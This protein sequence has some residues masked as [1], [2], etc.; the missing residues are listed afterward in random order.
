[1]PK[2][3]M[4][5]RRRH[6][7]YQL[8]T[9]SAAAVWLMTPGTA[10]ADCTP[11]PTPANG[12]VTCTGSDADGLTINTNQT[13]VNVQ[14]GATVSS[15]TATTIGDFDLFKTANPSPYSYYYPYPFAN[16]IT[17]NTSGQISGGLTVLSGTAIINH[18]NSPSTNVTLNV[19][20]GGSVSG[21]TAI[22]LIADPAALNPLQARA[23]IGID[24]SGS[25]QSTTGPAITGN[26]AYYS[27]VGFLRNRPGG[28]IGA[29]Q[30]P[31][32]YFYN[33]GTID[34]GTASAMTFAQSG[35]TVP[36]FPSG[37][38]NNDGSILSA[39]SPATLDVQTGYSSELTLY[40]SG[41]IRNAGS[42]SAISYNTIYKRM[43]LTNAAGGSI[44]SANG[45][46]IVSNAD[47]SISNSG[48]ISGAGTAIDVAGGLHL[49]GSGTITGSVNAGASGSA[50]STIDLS[51]GQTINGNL[52][53]GGGDDV[54]LVNYAGSLSGVP[55]V[56]GTVNAGGGT[57]RLTY[58]FASDATLGSAQTLPAT[59]SVLGLDIASGATVTLD[60]G[61]APQGLITLS[62]PGSAT[63]IN[64]ASYTVAGPAFTQ[65]YAY[66]P[67]AIDNRGALTVNLANPADT[68]ITMG[69]ASFAN[70]GSI[71]VNG[72]NG[73]SQLGSYYGNYG[74]LSTNSGSITA[75]ATALDI[76]G[77]KLTNSGTL[78]STAGTALRLSGYTSGPSSNSGSISGAQVGVDISYYRLINT[79]TIASP[80]TAVVLRSFGSLTNEASG[81]ID[82]NIGAPTGSFTFGSTVTNGGRIN[83]NVNFGAGQGFAANTF[84]ALDGSVVTGNLV[85]GTIDV[86]V[87]S[88]TNS[89]PGAYAGV[90][91]TVSGGGN[92]KLIYRVDADATTSLATPTS[93][94]STIGFDLA[95]NATL[96]L[97]GSSTTT[98]SFSGTGSVKISGDLTGSGPSSLINLQQYS[99]RVGYSNAI[100]LTSSGAL[101][102]TV[103]EPSLF[104]NGLV[105]SLSRDSSFT[106]SGTITVNDVSTRPSY[107]APLNAIY[108]LDGNVTNT[109]SIALG[110]V[111]GLSIDQSYYGGPD[112][113]NVSNS[114]SIT[115]IAGAADAVGIEGSFTLT[116]TGTISTGGRAISILK[117]S[118]ATTITNSG[119]IS[120]AHAPA[121]ADPANGYYSYLEPVSKIINQAGGTI[122]GGAGQSAIRLG[123]GV[124]DNAGTINGNV[125]LGIN[126]SAYQASYARS[127][128]IARGG[129]L[130]G[131]LTFGAGDDTLIVVG[132]STGV[133]GTIDAGGG[134]NTYA[135]LFTSS[136]SIDVTG[137]SLPATFQ[138]YAIGASGADTTLTVTGPSAG[139]SSPISFFGNGTIDNKANVNAAAAG[140]PAN[141]V[142]LGALDSMVGTTGGLSFVND[143]VLADGVSGSLR[144]FTNNGTVTAGQY[145]IPVRLEAVA[146]SDFSFNNTGQ[147][148]AQ[149]GTGAGYYYPAPMVSLLYYGA[150]ALNSATIANSGSISDGGLYTSLI[151]NQ[152]DV[153]NSGTISVP[154]GNPYY[155]VNALGIN[156]Y[157][158]GS[159]IG[160]VPKGSFTK[161][162]NTAA[163]T[164]NG[165]AYVSTTAEAL[166]I[167]N[168]GTINGNLI[169]DQTSLYT[170]LPASPGFSGGYFPVDQLSAS[171]TNSGAINGSL[172]LSSSAATASIANSGTVAANQN[173][174]AVQALVETNDGTTLKLTNSGTISNAA[175]GGQA[176]VAGAR[177]GFSFPD[178]GAAATLEV[179]NTGSLSAN[180]GA[181]LYS[182]CLYD[183][184]TGA[185]GAKLYAAAGLAVGASASGTASIAITN[186]AGATISAT[187]ATVSGDGQ[188]VPSALTKVGSIG[189]V[190]RADTVTLT[191][192]GTIS[193]GADM[194]PGSGIPAVIA[195][196]N[197]NSA[198]PDG[199]A[200]GVELIA[201]SATLTNAASGVIN[202]SVGLVTAAQGSVSNYGTINGNVTLAASDD[203]FVQ[204]IGATL[205]GIGDGGAGTDRLTIDI[206]GGGVLNPQLSH[207]I[208]FEST[209]LT[210]SGSVATSAPLATDTL[211]LDD[212]ALTIAAGKT[213]QTS[214]TVTLTGG[215]GTISITN[216]GTIAGKVVLGAGDESFM[217]GI[218]ASTGAVDGGAGTNSLTIDVSGGGNFTQAIAPFTN[219][220]SL[221]ATGTGTISASAPIDAATL[222][223]NNANLTLASGSTL[224]TSGAIALT[225]GTGTNAFTNNGTVNGA[226]VGV[227]TDNAAG[228]TVNVLASATNNARF[229][230]AA[231]DAT[232]AIKAGTY[233]LGQKLINSGL[234]A[235]SGG[236][237]LTDYA[238]IS[239]LAG[240]RI[241]VASGGTIND[242][243]DNAGTIVNSGT[244]NADLN[245]LAGGT[246]TNAAGA[247]WTGALSNAAGATLV[248]QGAAVGSI[249][250]SGTL[251]LTG[252]ST[253]SGQ[254]SNLAGGKIIGALA[255]GTGNDTLTLMSG[256]GVTDAIDGG[257]GSNT[258][259]IT[260]TGTD[261]APD[262]YNLTKVT[263]FQ[264]TT[265]TSG[266][267]AVSGSYTTTQLDILAGRYIGRTGSTLTATTLNVA[268]GATFGSGGTVNGNINV[269]GTLAPGGT[270]GAMTVNGN[271]AFASGSTALFDVG[272]AAS[273]QLAVTGAVSIASGATLTLSAVQNNPLKPGS[274][275]DLITSNGGITGS[276]GT[277]NKP[278]T[279]LGFVVQ[280]ATKISLLG[281][282]AVDSS[283]SAPVTTA[284]QAINSMLVSGSARPELINALPSL[285][286]GNGNTNAAAFAQLTPEAYASASQLG[287]DNGLTL[288]SALRTLDVARAPA[289]GNLFVFGQGLGSWTRLA[290]STALGTSR[291]RQS[292]GGVLGGLGYHAGPV[293]ISGFVGTISGNQTIAAL[294]ARTTADGIVAGANARFVSGGF[295]AAM[296]FAYDS[297]NADTTRPVPAAHDEQAHY[298]LRS[299]TF[300][301]NIG[302]S[303]SLGKSLKL[304]PGVGFTSVQTKR[305][306]ATEFG[307]SGV[308]DFALARD[309]YKANFIDGGLRIESTP[310][311]AAALHPWLDLGLRHLLDRDARFATGY[312]PGDVIGIKTA[313]AGRARTLTTV[314]A[315]F[316]LAVARNVTLYASYGGA[317][318]TGSSSSRVNGG[319]RMTF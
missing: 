132:N 207:F 199:F 1:M 317:F 99:P 35:T 67:V 130:N 187:G 70:S 140:Q 20:S 88:L 29:I 43:S 147:I 228:G 50:G 63:L 113:P 185:I 177:T 165:T 299:T 15:M 160:T 232:L 278:A 148:H 59:F 233:T 127:A 302:Y 291:V 19:A 206:T 51:G 283:F 175:S 161:L 240:G 74:Q 264:Q 170:Y 304:R 173:G 246:A 205:T 64:Q 248:N 57:N 31:V 155:P 98:Q 306:A 224:Q 56:T 62:S 79:G 54:V 208:N 236:A 136:S 61:F 150:E 76:S 154:P 163:G 261:A 289:S 300:D 318:G 156:A 295:D 217:Q 169:G 298:K 124:I 297:S 38:W 108:S 279:I 120:S 179:V 242:A 114:G 89:G 183:Y 225:G 227:D 319:I 214:G 313:G 171:I 106:N 68:A 229:T 144:G 260:S 168:A 213:L 45:T 107:Y 36:G 119:T 157:V 271:V 123:L 249:T 178:N 315:G 138:A 267:I 90:N 257:A 180:G 212:A 17:I 9:G 77:A 13:T 193:G 241:T 103:T 280:R 28:V 73:V 258:L 196:S 312:L 96:T 71:V 266:T 115:Q 273:D 162:T 221:A 16:N 192:N 133:T 86:F 189:V 311:N 102:A 85:L 181:L 135:Q 251:N 48:T 78:T 195:G 101:T 142:Q 158:N 153:T 303:M 268:S 210:G 293:A 117:G 316:D 281:Q 72:G 190:A 172:S 197:Y 95:N 141:T 116:N 256:A 226:I 216:Y 235:V 126:V 146:G 164:I 191:N 274:S 204:G 14:A 109:G 80:G 263:N 53:L 5:S 82:G 237:T 24:N 223:L 25:I 22:N 83:G 10:W 308:F 200:G 209:H 254:L 166:T 234:V 128:Y 262:E 8:L 58:K 184:S 238:G 282:F 143:A 259:R 152:L 41:T 69:Q 159:G 151:V 250:N 7:F 84:N 11:D 186:A 310:A 44:S 276:F 4:G 81:V 26:S 65:T 174:G 219:F 137:T 294:G 252:G 194:G 255:F 201:D 66:T 112:L 288:A 286:T 100:A 182:C 94:F 39:G 301:V 55:G 272:Q 222:T 23:Y 305:G 215:T 93:T 30:V 285:V 111:T 243:V 284:V 46:A 230:N 277:I 3:N 105:A 290:G 307:S 275:I 110:G 145:A 198:L 134:R 60:T 87:T 92:A 40:N 47:M 139:L 27:G 118:T 269:A 149:A 270:V 6:S 218:N 12:S 253:V 125:D 245:N 18:A 220:P 202:G 75:S 34:G 91:G 296:S 121:I 52:T 203:S 244:Y 292:A 287:T 167:D 176:I 21:A 104:V 265:L 309:T 231:A 42:G 97:T 37:S 33:S 211:I 122:S 129:T 247:I 2:V 131:N 239:N 49:T 32:S 314:G 188:A